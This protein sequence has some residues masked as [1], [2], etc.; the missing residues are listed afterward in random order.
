MSFFSYM[1]TGNFWKQI[2][3]ML[4]IVVILI[5]ASLLSLNIFTH[6][7]REIKVADICGFKVEQLQPYTEE[8]GFRF[9]VRDSIYHP[10]VEPGTILLQSPLPGSIVKRKRT[11]YVVV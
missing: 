5:G 3:L 6:H 4:I 9:V 1:K 2:L 8:F 11:F 10:N 7:G